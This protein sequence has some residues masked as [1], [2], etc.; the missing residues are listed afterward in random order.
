MPIVAVRVVVAIASSRI[1]LLAMF[2]GA[3]SIMATITAIAACDCCS[4]HHY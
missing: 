4:G 3:L 2:L 1:P